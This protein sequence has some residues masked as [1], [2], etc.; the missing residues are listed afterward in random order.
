VPWGEW[1]ARGTA[2]F[3]HLDWTDCVQVDFTSGRWMRRLVHLE[4]GLGMGGFLFDHVYDIHYVL[5][6]AK[7]P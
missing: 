6:P 5:V 7:S 1:D 2:I 4:P 3:R